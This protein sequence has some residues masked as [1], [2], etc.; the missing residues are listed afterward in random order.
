MAVLFDLDGTLVD[1]AYGLGFAL[2]KQLAL[3]GKPEVPYDVVRPVA[4]H[5]SSGLLQLGFG[6]KPTDANFE[7][8]KVEYLDLYESI[9]THKPI[10]LDGMEAMLDRLD[11]LNIPWG[12]VTNKPRRFAV[13]LLKAVR[14]GDRS[15]FDRSACL[16][17]GDDAPK[18]KPD[19][20]VMFMACREMQ[21]DPK[22][23]LYVGDA[24]RDVEAGKAAGM[25]TM[26]AL[27]GYIAETDRPAEWGADYLIATADELLGVI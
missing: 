5:G 21:V 9:L 4:S 19:P 2:N 27:F 6:I 1:T 18:P 16:F 3:H 7:A 26:V 8:M 22:D 25:K 23:C 14:M 15:L 11:V 13:D 12:I 24:Q 17:C 20:E 10:F